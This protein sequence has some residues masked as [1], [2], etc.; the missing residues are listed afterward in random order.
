MTLSDKNTTPELLKA[1]HPS[2]LEKKY[3]GT[4]KD[5]V[6]F[7]PPVMPSKEYGHDPEILVD[8][9]EYKLIIENNPG[10]ILRYFEFLS[11]IS[12]IDLIS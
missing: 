11:D 5:A 10:Y 4:A 12:F 6:K 2:Q 3:G 1:F 9:E 7:W 8:E